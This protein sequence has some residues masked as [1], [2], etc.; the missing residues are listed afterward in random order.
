M[1][2]EII[3]FVLILM[4]NIVFAITIDGNAY[5][6]NQTDHTGIKILFERTIPSS[7][8]DSTFSDSTGHFSL[9]LESGI[10]D[11]I[12]SKENYRT[13]YVIDEILYSN[14]T[15][16]DI[17]LSDIDI[18]AIL[19]VPSVYPTIQTAINESYSGDT[20]LV[21]SGTYYENI[22]FI[23]KGITVASNYLT[24]TD[25]IFISQT[26]IDGNLI[27][28]V[29][30]FI[31]AEDSTSIIN[32]FTLINGRGVEYGGGIKCINSNPKI[33]NLVVESN[34]A[35]NRG[36]GLYLENSNP[37]IINSVIIDNYS[38]NSFGGGIHMRFS[39]PIF[40]NVKIL[41]NNTS[42]GGHLYGGGIYGYSSNP[43]FQ[44]V[45]ISGNNADEA[46][47][48]VYLSESSAV[49]NN[50]II[51]DN[52]VTHYFGWGGGL[53]I[54]NS[55]SPISMNT[56][57]I[58]NNIALRAGGIYLYSSDVIGDKIIIYKNTSD[59]G[60]TGIRFT[61]SYS[62]LT[63]LVVEGNISNDTGNSGKA[64][65]CTN[66]SV[67]TIKNSIISNNENCYGIYIETNGGTLTSLYSDI[68]NNE[69]GNFYNCDQWT[70]INIAT[71][72]NGDS[73]DAYFNIQLDPCFV[74][75]ANGDYHLTIDSPCIDAGDP[76]SPLDP[77]GTIAD[78]GAYYFNQSAIIYPP[79]SEFTSNITE[80]YPPLLVDFTDLSIQGTG[81][82]TNWEWSFGVSDSSFVQNPTHIY[83]IAGTYDVSLTVTDE[84]DSTDTEIK[85]DYITVFVVPPAPP[86]NVLI[87]ISEEDVIISWTEV[88]STIFGT[89]INPD[90]YIIL[91]SEN[92]Y[93]EFNYLNF[94]PDTT[95][96]H[97]YVAEFRDQMFY[98]VVAYINY[99]R[100]QIEYLVGLNNS[101]D[102][103][104]WIDVKRKL[105]EFRK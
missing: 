54:S 49:F 102:K 42:T 76:A 35:L 5:L 38:H 65:Y 10:Y 25:T 33:N 40:E 32:G 67:V 68:W 2:K 89:P 20:V 100:E 84:N 92:P 61:D 34:T 48:G 83:Q 81:I 105:N 50:V 97:T 62:E 60:T 52:S 27:D 4:V 85:T 56:V 96:T 101:Q 98:Q 13:A 103:I 11:I 30:V 86:T 22:N 75:T 24:T 78:M 66:N 3:V 88:D 63:N 29:I 55:T 74:D 19:Y 43:T 14:T 8:I 71:N 87:N 70:G 12:Y 69:L 47:G 39:N 82:I 46:G 58:S 9:Q 31:N 95:Y 45:I 36:G 23:G 104:K 26:I 72:A 17:T 64:I 41:D 21:S 37:T 99:S 93:S 80:G 90:G 57:I 16:L 15:L 73:C 28:N 91:H 53:Y 44:N 79:I 7:L 1:K 18:P 6:E 94:T 59:F 51:D 77:D